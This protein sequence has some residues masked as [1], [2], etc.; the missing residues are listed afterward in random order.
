MPQH[1]AKFRNIHTSTQGKI[2]MQHTH[3]IWQLECRH[4]CGPPAIHNKTVTC[5]ESAESVDMGSGQS[6]F[7]ATLTINPHC[8]PFIA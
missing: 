8:M 4:L 3:S 6:A 7:H 5:I 2:K 1:K